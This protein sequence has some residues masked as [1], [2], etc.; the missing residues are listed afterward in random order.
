MAPAPRAA[1]HL[2]R[3]RVVHCAISA[4]VALDRTRRRSAAEPSRRT[5]A[6]P[7]PAVEADFLRRFSAFDRISVDVP[8][9]EVD[10]T[11]GYRPDL[12]QIIA[13]VNKD[14]P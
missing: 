6:D 11:D 10:T 8:W 12:D 14:A 3:I 1:G 9:I 2:A 5:H 13:F 7:G 4:E